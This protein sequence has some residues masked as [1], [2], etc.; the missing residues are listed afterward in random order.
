MLNVDL[1]TLRGQ[2]LRQLLDTT[3]RRG[4]AAVTYEI[5]QEMAVRR[6]R[7]E[8]EQRR[9]LFGPK[10]SAE[11]RV[12]ELNLGDPLDP[13]DPQLEEADM[14]PPHVE[15][16]ELEAA[17]QD[18]DAT[19]LHPP[20][21]GLNGSPE[22][23][24]RPP[25]PKPRRRA[26]WLST[27][28]AMGLVA[29]LALGGWA[30]SVSQ[31]AHAPLTVAAATPPP[32]QAPAAAAPAGD[33][34]AVETE[35]APATAAASV[36]GAVTPIPAPPPSMASAPIP[37]AV[38]AVKTAP[39]TAAPA[40]VEVAEETAPDTGK[41][42]V[43]EAAA[44]E[45]AI[46]P[47][48]AKACAGQPTPADRIICETPRLQRLQKDL[49]QAYADALDAHQDRDLLREH[50]LAWREARNTV[51]EPQR[52]AQLYEERIRKLN[53]AAAEARAAR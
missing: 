23:D 1:S 45:A 47:V 16:W 40:P 8:P 11:P 5:L 7:G 19:Y 26:L 18:D 28:L 48:G 31:Q 38:P 10:R 22:F 13:K 4:D 36:P 53:A 49:R 20:P 9:G 2:E 3:R 46:G 21:P 17:E 6:E 50:Q 35:T 39:E 37:A 33:P 15:D 44:K 30:E 41:A 32:A 52:L 14:A 42:A 24:D 43:K 34:I 29:G 12:I 51:T 27:G 25:P